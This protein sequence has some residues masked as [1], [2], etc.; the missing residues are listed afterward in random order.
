MKHI[1]TSAAL[2]LA[3]LVVC[4]PRSTARAEGHHQSGIVG[5]VVWAISSEEIETPAQC[6][7]NVVSKSAKTTV[8]VETDA[9]GSFRVALKP[10]T[11]LLTPFLPLSPD[12]AVL[13]GPTQQ[14]TVKKKDYAEI[15]LQFAWSVVPPWLPDW[16]WLLGWGLDIETV[17]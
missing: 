2:S 5:Q 16:P 13:I 15:A 9:N 1:T 10:G 17:P 6:F 8:T 4:F 3:L 7:V 12:G 11:Y 14:I